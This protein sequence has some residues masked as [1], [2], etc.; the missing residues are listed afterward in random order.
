[1]MRP[2]SKYY[3]GTIQWNSNINSNSHCRANRQTHPDFRQSRCR[4]C[5]SPG[6]RCCT[7]PQRP[8]SS[9]CCRWTPCCCRCSGC[10]RHRGSPSPEHQSERLK[11]T[12]TE[13]VSL[14]GDALSIQ[15]TFKSF[16]SNCRHIILEVFSDRQ[17]N[18]WRDLTRQ[19]ISLSQST[20]WLP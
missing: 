18:P 20:F 4:A 10:C 13:R 7:C 16:E 2:T 3:L 12:E 17:L 15:A 19:G 14:W 5:W 6:G 1:M 11:H 8:R 9:G